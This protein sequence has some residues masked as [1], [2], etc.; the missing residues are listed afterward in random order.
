MI[1][2]VILCILFI[3][4][5][6]CKDMPP[7][8]D[9]TQLKHVEVTVKTHCFYECFVLIVYHSTF[10]HVSASLRNIAWIFINVCFQSFQFVSWY[11][12]L[13]NDLTNI[14][15]HVSVLGINSLLTDPVKQTFLFAFVFKHKDRH[16]I[17]WFRD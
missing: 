8:D 11:G 17:F 13:C 4:I 10:E 15:L 2:K 6:A 12:Y 14:K 1:I 9:Q 3:V 5:C 16:F 7:R